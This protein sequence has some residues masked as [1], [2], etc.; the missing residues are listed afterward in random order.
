MLYGEIEKNTEYLFATALKKCNNLEDA[1]ELMQEV[2]LA[3]LSYKSDV[4]NVRAWLSSVLNHKFYDMIRR[5]YK[6][7]TV[8]I[9]MLR[10]IAN[11]LPMMNIAPARTAEHGSPSAAYIRMILISRTSGSAN[12][13]T[14]ANAGRALKNF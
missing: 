7:P 1:K 11:L 5:R 4:V 10:R 13:V 2:L 9:D 12:T 8:S 14:A 6:L 3:A